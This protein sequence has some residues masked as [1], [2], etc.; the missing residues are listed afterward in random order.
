MP[1][2]PTCKPAVQTSDPTL[3][4]SVLARTIMDQHGLTDWAFDLDNAKR[5]AG[6]C[7]YRSKIITLSRHYVERNL[8]KPDD[9]RDTILHEVAHAL[10]GHA[11]GHGDA[12]KAVCVQ[13]GA[14]PKRCYDSQAINMPKGKYQAV[15]G[16]CQKVFTRHRRVKPLTYRYCLACG[17]DKGRLKFVQ[18]V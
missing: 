18:Q 14:R 12:W 8:D 11:A 4:Y 13:I 2:V 3:R 16:G 15:C 1:L 9:L 10:A 17:T 5:R 6:C 7:F